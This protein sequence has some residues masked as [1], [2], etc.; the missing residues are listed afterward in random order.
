MLQRV[1][2]Q[3]LTIERRHRPSAVIVVWQA[4]GERV[5]KGRL[6]FVFGHNHHRAERS[7]FLAQRE[8]PGNRRNVVILILHPNGDRSCS[9]LGG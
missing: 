2:R 3:T 4:E 9:R 5:R 6:I 1:Q 8:I 7:V